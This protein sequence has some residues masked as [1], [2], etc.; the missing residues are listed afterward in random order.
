MYER[1]VPGGALHLNSTG[2]QDHGRYGNLPL[3]G[4]I[5]TTEPGIEPATSWLVIRSSDHQATRI[6]ES[7]MFETA[8]V[9][10]IKHI[11]CPITFPPENRAVF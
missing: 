4:E 10:K 1:G 5:A 6:V 9:E 2:Y 8:V 7:E 3:Q 11:L